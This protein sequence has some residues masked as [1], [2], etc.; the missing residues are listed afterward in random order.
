MTDDEPRVSEEGNFS[1]RSRG[2]YFTVTFLRESVLTMCSIMI[3]GSDDL[4][5]GWAV[6]S[7]DDGQDDGV[8]RRVALRRAIARTALDKTQRRSIWLAYFTRPNR[9]GGEVET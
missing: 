1:V 2:C 5:P 7:R 8:G 6:R 9:P 3:R 4:W